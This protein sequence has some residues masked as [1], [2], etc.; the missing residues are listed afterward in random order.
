VSLPLKARL[1]RLLPPGPAFIATYAPDPAKLEAAADLLGND[2]VTNLLVP[3]YLSGGVG[4]AARQHA[5]M[6]MG[7]GV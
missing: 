1:D 4:A 2:D 5:E 3:P 7:G 6:R